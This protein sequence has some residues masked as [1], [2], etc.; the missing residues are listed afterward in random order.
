MG[1]FSFL[2]PKN[3]TVYDLFQINLNELPDSSFIDEGYIYDKE[4][5]KSRFYTKSLDYLECGVFSEIE[6][7]IGDN[8]KS[9][10]FCSKPSTNIN[11]K[12]FCELANSLYHIYGNDDSNEGIITS[13]ELI[14]SVNNGYLARFW[15]L[16]NHPM[17]CITA[18][19]VDDN[20]IRLKV[21]DITSEGTKDENPKKTIYELFKT[22]LKELPDKRFN[23]NGFVSSEKVAGFFSFDL[24]LDY[25]ECGIFNEIN[26]HQHEKG[27]M[28]IFFNST[29]LLNVE[30]EKVKELVDSLYNLYGTDVNDRGKF[31]EQENNEFYG[32][33]DLSLRTWLDPELPFEMID[34]SVDREN[35]EISL[36]IIVSKTN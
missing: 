4:Q 8:F 28:T 12:K 9:V 2:L 20:I 23:A 5:R 17:I 19:D 30:L 11:T 34:I 35:N 29:N 7:T 14:D 18:F 26:V 16:R 27:G 1:L 32:H 21:M 13:Q 24:T 33:H 31:T 25:L 3:K 22:N 6:V 15:Y 10:E 36:I